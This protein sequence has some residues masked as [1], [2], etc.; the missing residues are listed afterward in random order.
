MQAASFRVGPKCPSRLHARAA[1]QAPRTFRTQSRR[2]Q[3]AHA[4]W[5]ESMT[6]ADLKA[7][8]DAALEIE[9]YSQAA[10]LRDA[11]Q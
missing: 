1:F 5:D 4:I 10:K 2:L 7:Q 9:D 8:L 3:V 6:L 11:I